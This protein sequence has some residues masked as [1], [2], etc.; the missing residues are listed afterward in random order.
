MAHQV[1]VG[2]GEQ[3]T[4]DLLRFLGGCPFGALAAFDSPKVETAWEERLEKQLEE[5]LVSHTRTAAPRRQLLP[6]VP[7]RGTARPFDRGPLDALD[8]LQCFVA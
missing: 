6:S 1:R 7:L 8:F 5:R 2:I 3:T 4:P